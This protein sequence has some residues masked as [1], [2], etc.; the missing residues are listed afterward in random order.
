MLV[1]LQ[2]FC[3]DLKQ[4]ENGKCV[5]DSALSEYLVQNLFKPYMAGKE[6]RLDSLD[7]DSFTMTDLD[8]LYHFMGD[9]GTVG[10]KLESMRSSL[11]KCNPAA[12][13]IKG[14]C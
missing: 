12:R 2:T 6:V 8:L 9:L 14:F 13:K 11:Q 4:A 10:Q 5:D 3:T 1:D 7:Y